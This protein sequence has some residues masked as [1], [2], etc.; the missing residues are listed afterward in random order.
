MWETSNVR[1]SLSVVGEDVDPEAVSDLLGSPPD[2]SHRLG[3]FGSSDPDGSPVPP[4]GHWGISTEGRIPEDEPLSRHV[5]SLLDRVTA[6]VPTWREL[7]D[8]YSCRIFV[9]WFMAQRNEMVS[10]DPELLGALAE[11]QLRL[12]VDLYCPDELTKASNLLTE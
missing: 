2:R 9:G 5:Q 4:R 1:V 10:L 8:K 11:R 7:A 3:D 6:N 12:E